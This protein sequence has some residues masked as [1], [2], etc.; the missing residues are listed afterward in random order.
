MNPFLNQIASKDTIELMARF[1]DAANNAVKR[2][3]Y[4][5][6]TLEAFDLIQAI[7]CFR[8]FPT[9]DSCIQAFP[10]LT[11][12]KHKVEYIWE[13]FTKLTSKQLS[14]VFIS[15]LRK[16]QFEDEIIN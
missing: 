5:N 6:D 3:N 8:Y 2:A 14:E 12:D 13:Q 16:L 9:V 1:F 15:S 11:N 4:N 7:S 10:T